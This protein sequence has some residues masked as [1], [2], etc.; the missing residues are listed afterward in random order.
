MKTFVPGHVWVARPDTCGLR[1][2]V[3]HG[4]RSATGQG[5]AQAFAA[6]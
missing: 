1:A 3:V 6:R 4:K 5:H 2:R